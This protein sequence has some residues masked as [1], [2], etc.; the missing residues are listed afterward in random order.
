[1][2]VNVVIQLAPCL[3]VYAL[4]DWTKAPTTQTDLANEINHGEHIPTHTDAKAGQPTIDS[5]SYHPA[6][7]PLFVNH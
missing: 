5:A 2:L 6:A 3:F 1:M 7:P 4:R